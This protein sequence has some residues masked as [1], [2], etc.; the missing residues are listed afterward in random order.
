M[1]A[2]SFDVSRVKLNSSP[3]LREVLSGFGREDDRL[4]LGDKEMTCYGSNGRIT[5]SPVHILVA[6]SEMVLTGSVGLD[7]SLQYILQVPLTPGLVGREA[8]R[9][10]KGTMVR[11]PIRGTIGHPAFDRNMVVDTVRDLVQHAAGRVINQQLE[12]VLPDLL[13]GVFGAPPQQ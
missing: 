6:G 3:L 13:P 11:V 7:Q 2:G 4:R 10:L 9:I 5:C 12:K 8:Y 1:S